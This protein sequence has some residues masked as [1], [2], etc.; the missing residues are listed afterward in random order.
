MK[1]YKVV[2]IDDELL[3]IDVI[4]HYFSVFPNYVV[5]KTFINPVEAV[6]FLK[7]NNV[8]L[9]FTDIAMP[10][11]S[12]IDLVKL[13]KDTTK[14]V[15]TTS[16]SEFALE[17]FELNVVDYLLKPVSLERFSKTL[18]HFESSDKLETEREQSFFVKDGDE[19]IK[20]FIEKI[21]YIEGMKDY[22][23]I[24][25]GN[26]YYMVLKTLKALEEFL[27]P[28]DFQRIHK[29]FIVPLKKIDQ[30][31]NRCVLV[32]NKEIPLGPAYRERLKEYLNKHKL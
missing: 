30:S 32:N 11:I 4:T 17:S 1:N 19:F 8:D 27:K 31:N 22:A 7:M 28:Y 10:N 13:L 21:D 25:C 29:S 14:F 3:A 20:V 2:V 26:K 6:S 12:G 18:K 15:M 23:K 24:I 5:L 9:V 16:F